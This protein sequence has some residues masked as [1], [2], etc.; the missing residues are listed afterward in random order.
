MKIF[1]GYIYLIQNIQNNKIYIGQT[2]QR[3]ETY[4]KRHISNAERNKDSNT[5]YLYRAIRKYGFSNFKC[6]ILGYCN[7]EE[8]LNEAEI[9]CIEFFQSNNFIYG[10]NMTLGGEGAKGLK[11]TEKYKKQKSIALL[12][13]KFNLGKKHTEET[14]QI[15]REAATGKTPSEETRQKISGA[16]IKDKNP[17]WRHD[18]IDEDIV[19][20]YLNGYSIEDIAKRLDCCSYLISKRLKGLR[21]QKRKRIIKEGYIPP[22][23]GKHLSEEH[24]RKISES[25]KGKI[26]SEE[27]RKKISEKAKGRVSPNK[28]KIMSEE[29]RKKMSIAKKDKKQTQEH[30][31]NAQT[32]KKRNKE[33]KNL[34]LM[35]IMQLIIII[36][37]LKDVEI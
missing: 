37:N 27:S 17:R 34:Y 11:H 6:E 22:F 24:K 19:K 7:S 35:Q 25:N 26:L 13:N 9:A 36:Y 18:V 10:Y 3:F 31:N 8:E 2:T 14:K 16:K 32:A 23:K 28:G 4:I 5:R 15:L 20:L 12:G 21:L 1:K 33:L 30:I 29:S